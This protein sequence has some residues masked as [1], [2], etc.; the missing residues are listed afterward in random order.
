MDIMPTTVKDMMLNGYASLA[1]PVGTGG[2]CMGLSEEQRQQRIDAQKGEVQAR[3]L[4]AAL[5]KD[6]LA[7]KVRIADDREREREKKIGL[8]SDEDIELGYSLVARDKWS[9]PIERISALDS[10]RDMRGL[11]TKAKDG[12]GTDKLLA[13]LQAT[14]ERFNGSGGV[15]GGKD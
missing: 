15:K 13:D 4:E 3:L 14:L 5:E 8:L 1:T 10:L 11:K 12:A 7:L 9:T 6:R 2:S